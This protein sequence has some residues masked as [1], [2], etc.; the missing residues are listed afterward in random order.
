MIISGKFRITETEP[1]PLVNDFGTFTQYLSNNLCILTPKNEFI[2]RNDLHALNQQMLQSD[3]KSVP[4]KDQNLYPLLHLFYHLA[5]AGKLVQKGAG[6]GSRVVL[7]PTDRIQLYNMLNCTEKYMFL[8]ETFW[9]DANWAKLQAGYFGR[10]PLLMVPQ[11]LGMVSQARPGRKIQV[12][13][14]GVFVKGMAMDFMDLEYFWFYFTYFG[15]WHISPYRNEDDWDRPKR[16]VL[17]ESFTPTVLGV[18]LASIMREA[19]DLLEWNQPYH[20]NSLDVLPGMWDRLLYQLESKLY[21]G[22]RKS[23]FQQTK[24][25]PDEPPTSF[26]KYNLMRECAFQQ[27]KI[28]TD[29]PFIRPFIPLFEKDALQKTLSRDEG[30]FVE[31]T[32]IFKVTLNKDLWRRIKISSDDTLLELHEAIQRAFNF[33]DDHL[34]AFFMDGKPWSEERFV[35]PE[36]EE[37]PYVDEIRI[38]ELGLFIGQKIMYLFDYG[39]EWRFSVKLEQITNEEHEIIR[40]EIIKRK[41]EN[42]KQYW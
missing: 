28:E 4:Q 26:G 13:N 20:R 36:D 40:S 14:D 23:A 3:L 39:D 24:I 2:S 35:A 16:M 7:K 9:V 15:F 19:R 10:S 8:L 27:T 30:K 17:V 22:N 29:E 12:M 1:T 21:F 18:N 31:G 25:E 32:Y 34:Y 6:K 42:P 11:I 5:L 38:G 37:G 33:D 41:G